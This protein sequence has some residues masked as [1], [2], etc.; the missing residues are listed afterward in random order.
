MAVQ[1]VNAGQARAVLQHRHA[2]Y[3]AN[4]LCV[5]Q[6]PEEKLDG[7]GRTISG[8]PAVSHCYTRT[9][10]EGWPYNFYVMIHA[11]DRERCEEIAE[12]IECEHHLSERRMFYSVK[13][14]KKASMKYFQD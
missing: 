13:E 8:E 1:A 12:R 6:V 4:A 7:L 2:G 3:T 14:W 9:A 5:W 10:A 11:H